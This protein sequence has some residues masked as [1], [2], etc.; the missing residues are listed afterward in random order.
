MGGVVSESTAAPATPPGL[1]LY[2]Y[3]G[4]RT[5]PCADPGYA[6]GDGPYVLYHAPMW[7]LNKHLIAADEP[8]QLE[9]F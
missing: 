4:M 8:V 6:P 5:R 3:L 9:L 2:E 7:D 1:E